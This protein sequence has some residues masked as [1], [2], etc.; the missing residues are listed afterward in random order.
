MSTELL[1]YYEWRR[2]IGGSVLVV[3]IALTAWYRPSWV[4]SYTTRWRSDAAAALNVVSFLLLFLLL[5]VLLQRLFGVFEPAPPPGS[6]TWCA[7]GL[8]VCAI[9]APHLSRPLRNLLMLRIANMPAEAQRL[10]GRLGDANFRSPPERAERARVMLLRSGIDAQADPLAITQSAYRLLIRAA[11]LFLQIRE[12]EANSQYGDFLLEARNEFD[13]LRQRFHR[14]TLRS[15]RALKTIERVGE[16]RLQFNEASP[17]ADQDEETDRLL[18]AM[19]HDSLASLCEDANAFLVDANL[20]CARAALTLHRGAGG[21]DKALQC[22]GFELP[23]EPTARLYGGLLQGIL[24]LFFGL[25]VYFWLA[26]RLPS[27]VL[28]QHQLF[29]VILLTQAGALASA[30]VP[31]LHFGFANAGLTRR[32]PV[33]FV[34]AAGLASV[35][36]MLAINL[37][38]GSLVNGWAGVVARLSE[39]RFFTLSPFMTA[40]VLAWLIQDHRWR[41]LSPTRRRL[42]DALVM[43]CSWMSVSTLLQLLIFTG[44]I[45]R[46]HPELSDVLFNVLFS[47]FL[48]GVIGWV[49]PRL[50]RGEHPAATITTTVAPATVRLQAALQA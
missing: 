23:P 34:F 6:A 20:L 12:W 41:R 3:V 30:I 26:P 10:A 18:R 15:A 39:A 49:V 9:L 46:G 40:A 27:K 38:A 14:M 1:Q 37:V 13:E 35:A 44:V 8:T 32:T 43:G 28:E 19:V 47:L 7:M 45:Q 36:V 22:M 11:E 33:A 29:L 2:T 50:A 4:S 24:V 42:C 21:R 5:N 48:G 16:L 25:V 17:S 31:K